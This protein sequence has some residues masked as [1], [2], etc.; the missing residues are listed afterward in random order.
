MVDNFR[1]PAAAASNSVDLSAAPEKISSASPL[2]LE[3]AASREQDARLQALIGSIDEMVFEVDRDGTFINIWTT[4]EDLLYRPL[5]ELKGKRVSEAISEDFFRPLSMILQRVF[6]SGRGE[7]MEYL[8]KVPLGERWFLARVNRI[9]SADG[10]HHTL[11]LAVRDITD[12]KHAEIALQKSE[13]KFSRAFHL[14]P[15]AIVI[16]SVD[17]GRFVE[18]N[19]N[20]L[21]LTG[22]TRPE[23]LGRT[24]VEAGIWPN[25]KDR[26]QLVAL[27]KR[28]SE[29]RDLEMRISIKSGEQRTVQISVHTIN[30][31][32]A[33]CLISIL[34]DCTERKALEEQLRQAQKMEAVGRLA[35]GVA[36][37]FNNLL[38]GILGYSDLLKKKLSE[39]G[40]LLRMANEINFAAMR[41]RDLT[42]RLL[43]LS[44]R[45]V[46]QPQVLD[47]NVL[48]RD[49]E[50][51]L[52]PVIAEDIRV[53]L[54]LDTKV[55]A[56]KADPAQLEQVVLN[57]VLNARDALPAGGAISLVTCS[58][59]VDAA[60]A[61]QHPGLIPGSYV[62]LCVAD[63][64]QGIPPEVM[65]RIFEP[66]FT[67]KQTGKGSGL[68]LSSV[69][70][71]VKQTGGCVT[72]SSEPG[73]GTTFGIYLPRASEAPERRAPTRTSAQPSSGTE[74]ILLVEDE[75]V[76]RDLV[77][78]ILRETGYQ[79]LCAPSGVE[80]LQVAGEHSAP[81]HL[82]VTDVVMPE[83]SGPEL[84]NRLCHLRT[85]MRV[86]Y[87]S[88]YT[89]DALLGR[90]GLPEQSVFIQKPYT[91]EQF[92]RKVR[93]TLDL[94]S[95]RQR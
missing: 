53:T 47:L 76:V 70:G 46:L 43:A 14:G 57:L 42:S 24:S 33:P 89:D 34:R 50:R 62:R 80:A 68:G 23:L 44:R 27:L 12:R 55:G 85:K 63:T 92:L 39:Q 84:A 11:C 49:C 4:N 56:V 87:M 13:E 66:F 78:D 74:T 31:G 9:P 94:R 6:S 59:Q 54:R 29:V 73:K 20:F 93:E 2:A 10:A 88:G 60:L 69:Y 77:C 64:G 32:N 90:K 7:D 72:V 35:G 95:G 52:R 36:H 5:H 51:L 17:D 67:T 26:E 83:M 40:P 75:A 81:I 16:T 79:V 41:A 15:D 86:L 65:P 45:Q 91:P 8:L 18:V 61:R 22:F 30:L 3:H 25:R 37:D 71:I 28:S 58:I 21:R 19:D 38:V 1:T 48:V 82:L